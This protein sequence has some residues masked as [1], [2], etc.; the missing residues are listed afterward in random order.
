MAKALQPAVTAG[1]IFFEL[2]R[3]QSSGDRLEL[4]GR[5]F[6]VRGR[7]FMRPSLVLLAD[8]TNF[9]ALAELEHKPWAAEDGEPW[10]AAFPWTSDAELLAAELSVGPDITVRLPAPSPDLDPSQ[11]LPVL[12]SHGGLTISPERPPRPDPGASVETP[13]PVTEPATAARQ[14]TDDGKKPAPRRRKS[15]TRAELDAVTEQLARSHSEVERLRSELEASRSELDAERAGR[16]EASEAANAE[17]AGALEAAKL[18]IA[19]ALAR[20]DAAVSSGDQ[21]LGERDAA[22]AHRDEAAAERARAISERDRAR[23]SFRRMKAEFEQA[24]AAAEQ[25]ARE[26]EA[27]LAA[28]HQAIGER[29]ALRQ[30]GEQLAQ[31]RNEAISSRGAALVMRN[32]ANALP[33][34]ERHAGWFR[35]G[36]AIVVLLGAVFALLVITHVL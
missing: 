11:R 26:R 2:D 7:R 32:A 35:R 9:R 17:S 10:E 24:R 16:A 33:S 29:D 13:A 34:Y 12:P 23:E 4:S 20:R 8:G 3:F 30:S 22:L 28:Q 21:A 31:A 5:W 36:V 19:A 1:S 27:A 15:P 14:A 18:E 25:A 6:G